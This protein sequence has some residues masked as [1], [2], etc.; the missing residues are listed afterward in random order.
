M[1]A[2]HQLVPSLQPGDAT[3]AH[4]LEVQRLLRDLGF[5]SE[6]YAQAVHPALSPRARLVERW[7]GPGARDQ[8]LLYQ[9]AA[10]SGLADR[11]V[12]GSP[13]AL[14]YHNVTPPELFRPW[15]RDIA[16]SMQAARLQLGQLAPHLSLGVCV[17]SFNA[18]DLGRYGVR[19]RVVAPVLVDVAA[20]DDE[21]DVAVL[22]RL[23]RHRDA[24]ALN[25][26]FVGG[27]APHK[28]QHR[29]VQAL[30][31]Y[32]AT[33]DRRARLSL[34]GR[35]VAPGY[36]AALQ[37]L[38][39][40]L[41]LGDAVD[42]PGSV[43]HAELVAHYRGADVFVSLSAHEGF[44]VPVLEA[45]H[46]GVPVVALGAGAVP[47]TVGDGALVLDESNPAGVAAAVHRVVHD[48]P[49][50]DVL[51]RAGHGR[52]AH[53]SLARSRDRMG[54]VLRRWVAAG[55]VWPAQEPVTEEPVT[56]EP[57]TRAP[58]TAVA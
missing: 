37:A 45:M 31:V 4:T 1:T 52:V 19:P 26:L 21:P 17:S 12:G 30:A 36:A 15:D 20:F 46:H 14:N 16:L 18:D 11:V 58:V 9:Y 2:V 44:C 29:L 5:D 53:F 56:E 10:V 13:V 57:P 40:R 27:I 24:G 34:V 50:R 55:G 48:R 32:R 23:A 25:W 51:A 39:D 47:D 38:V 22:D 33:Y 3:T 28:A 49:L 43:S 54:T 8:F 7:A 6:V 42:L 41:D 35:V